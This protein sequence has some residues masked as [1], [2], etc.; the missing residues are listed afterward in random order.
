ML[1]IKFG[2]V[3]CRIDD[4]RIILFQRS[5][6]SGMNK[7]FHGDKFIEFD[8]TNIICHSWMVVVD[9]VVPQPDIFEFIKI[10]TDLVNDT[11]GVLIDNI[12][13]SR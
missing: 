13:F 4:T 8:T 5:V 2:F 7:R 3:P 11:D 10:C 6:M 1:T 12:N 9:G